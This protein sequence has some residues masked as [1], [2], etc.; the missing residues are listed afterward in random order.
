MFATVQDVIFVGLALVVYA[1]EVWALVDAAVTRPE[2]FLAAGKRT[3][4][5]WLLLLGGAAVA[6]FLAT[7][8]PLG[9]ELMPADGGTAAQLGLPS[10]I[11]WGAVVP[12]VIYLANVRPL[13]RAHSRLQPP[14]RGD[15]ARPRHG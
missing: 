12:A 5:L 1:V 11:A 9:L 4:G 10:L 13:V 6:G 14:R 3:R 8:R 2:A 15:E 7:P